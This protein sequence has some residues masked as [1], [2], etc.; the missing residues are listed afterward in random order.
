MSNT[1]IDRFPPNQPETQRMR[2]ARLSEGV[3]PPAFLT[4]ITVLRR[5]CGID[6]AS[7]IML[8]N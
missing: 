1:I 2:I 7:R 3:R 8:L 6:I 4:V 5:N